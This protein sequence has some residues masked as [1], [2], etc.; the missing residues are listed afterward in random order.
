MRSH[1]PDILHE[2]ALYPSIQL[3][4]CSAL[5]GVWKK[6]IQR[7]VILTYVAVNYTL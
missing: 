1:Q 7:C 4:V 5:L 3:C 6:V 2:I